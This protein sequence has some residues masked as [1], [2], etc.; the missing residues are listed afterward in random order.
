[1]TIG[2]VADQFEGILDEF[3]GTGTCRGAHGADIACEPSELKQ[4]IVELGDLDV[5]PRNLVVDDGESLRI[6]HR[7]A[8]TA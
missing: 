4:V 7:E 8:P 1:M 5:H 3:D 2:L 6:G